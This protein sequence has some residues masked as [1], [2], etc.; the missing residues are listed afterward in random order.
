M[1]K[2]VKGLF[3]FF[4]ACVFFIIVGVIVGAMADGGSET[5]KKVADT[6]TTATPVKDERVNM[7]NY[8][9]IKI[10]DSM[11]GKGGMSLEE[12]TAIMGEPSDKTET[13]SGNIKM[14]IAT[15]MDEEFNTITVSFMNNKADS[16]TQTGV[17]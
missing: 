5:A 7:E 2:F 3:I 4:G 8:N 10:G 16:K 13:Q 14:V 15:W 9:K 1:K 12:V 6:V 11:T 17:E